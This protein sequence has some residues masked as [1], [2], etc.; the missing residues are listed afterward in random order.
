MGHRQTGTSTSEHHPPQREGLKRSPPSSNG[1]PD[2]D[3][4]SVVAGKIARPQPKGPTIR[5]RPLLYGVAGLSVVLLIALA[6]RPASIPVDIGTVT[7]GP[8]QVT[9]DAE[10]KTRVQER[11]VVSAPVAG[12]LQRIDLDAGDRVEKGTVIAQLDPLPLTSQVQSA[13][14]WA[15]P[16]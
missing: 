11:Y 15:I 2:H 7:E 14:S 6:F 13:P 4:S 10:G 3:P 8:L 1:K 9:I 12:R 5:L 16:E